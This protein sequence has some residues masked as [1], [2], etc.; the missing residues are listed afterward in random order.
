MTA[1]LPVPE[2]WVITD[3]LLERTSDGCLRAGARAL[4]DTALHGAPAVVRSSAENEDVPLATGAGVYRSH[5]DR[6]T[7]EEIVSAVRWVRAARAEADARAYHRMRR[8]SGGGRVHV[9]VQRMINCRTWGVLYTRDPVSDEPGMLVESSRGTSVPVVA[10]LGCEESYV[11]PPAAAGVAGP[12]SWELDGR[13]LPDL[14]WR[15]GG[16][17]EREFGGPLDV[18][19]GEDG[20]RLWVF[21]ARSLAPAG[22]V[23]AARYRPR[24]PSTA[25]RVTPLSRGYAVGMPVPPSPGPVRPGAIVRLP[26]LPTAGELEGL[27]RAA[28]LVVH[29]GNVLSHSGA[30]CRE[31]GLP[32]ALAPGGL[33]GDW[34]GPVLLDAVAGAVAPLSALPPRE[35]AAAVAAVQFRAGLRPERDG[36]PRY[37]APLHAGRRRQSVGH[38]RPPATARRRAAGRAELWLAER[39]MSAFAGGRAVLLSVAGTPRVRF[40]RAG[41]EVAVPSWRAGGALLDRLGFRRVRRV[42]KSAVRHGGTGR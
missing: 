36:G 25:L 42:G 30:L 33:P 4:V 7:P 39:H 18:E 20:Q 8:G 27:R 21:Q 26:V 29:A 35:R 32:V 15:L 31:A 2:T 22:P 37:P 24:P 41:V 17:L 11:L 23:P 13:P 16:V 10:G 1:G 38:R 40:G 19:W 9:L 6:R 5:L 14:L 3:A 28:G 34:A 12:A